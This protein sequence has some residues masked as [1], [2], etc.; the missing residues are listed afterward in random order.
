MSDQVTLFVTHYNRSQ[1]LERLLQTLAGQ[2]ILF[3]H[4]VVSDDGSTVE[5]RE[6]LNQL[7]EQYG[8][9]LVQSERNQGLGHNMNKGQDAVTTPLTLYIQEDFVPTA[10]FRKAY[11]DALSIL[12][13]DPQ[14]DLVRFFSNFKYPYTVPFRDHFSKM[15]AP[16]WGLDYKKIYLYSDGPHLR[17]SNF[18]EK[19]GRYREG[20]HGDRTEYWMCVSFIQ[21]GGKAI[22]YDDYK[23]LFEHVNT[24]TEP[25]QIPRAPWNPNPNRM[26]HAA[27]S[28][29]RQVRYNFD[30]VFRCVL[31]VLGV[32]CPGVIPADL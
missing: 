15:F 1:S 13:E 4:V 11:E 10:K 19:F 22:I 14:V 9:T 30:I 25:S 23:A 2:G 32:G 8:F 28:L 31:L 29:Y 18:L 16:L 3:T 21:K 27:K 5:H 24:D 6:K 20:I 7:K 26:L 12:N 17:R